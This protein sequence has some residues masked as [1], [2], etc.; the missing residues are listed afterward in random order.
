M[1]LFP[2]FYRDNQTAVKMGNIKVV[3]ASAGSGK[4]FNLVYEY[5]RNVVVEPSL[6]RHILAVTFTNKATEEMKGRILQRVHELASGEE[7]AYMSMLIQ[8]TGKSE[9]EIRLRAQMAQNNILHDY[10]HFAVLT[11]DKFFQR[12]VRS[13]IKELGIDLNFNIELPVDTLLDVSVDR[14][15]ESLATDEQLREWVEESIGDMLD[16]GKAWDLRN[17]WKQTGKDLF[18][19]N[20]KRA[21]KSW[22]GDKTMLRKI[23]DAAR[24]ESNKCRERIIAPAKRILDIIYENGLTIDDIC[25]K[26]KGVAGYVA[27]VAA[28]NISEYG[29]RVTDILNGGQWYAKSASKSQKERI[30]AISPALTSLLEELVTE[31]DKGVRLIHTVSILNQRYRNFALLNDIKDKMDEVAKEENIV[32]ISEINEMLA[33]LIS[34]N[35]TP[36]VFEKAGNYYSHFMIDEFQDTSAMQWENFKPLLR[37]AVSQSEGEP[38]MLVG[39]I[40]QSIYR[41]RGGDWRIL[42]EGVDAAFNN[43]RHSSLR[44]NYRSRRMVVDFVNA[45]MSECVTVENDKVNQVLYQAMQNGNIPN[46]LYDYLR[47]TVATV[48]ADCVQEPA[49]SE[50]SGYVTITYYADSVPPIISMVEQLQERGYKAGDIAILVRTNNEARGIAEMMLEYKMQNHDSQYC[51]DVI[52]QDALVVGSSDEVAFI[53]ACLRL[54]CNREL[55]IAKAVYNRFL[56][57]GV[58]DSFDDE[59]EKFF[60]RLSMMPPEEAFEAVVSHCSLSGNDNAVLYMQALQDQI[61]SFSKTHVADISLFLEQW[62]EQGSSASIPMSA[63]GN[64]ITIDTIHRSK[65]L[66]YKAV[67]IPYCDWDM[68]PKTSTVIWALQHDESPAK[69]LGRFP[70]QYTDLTRNSLFSADYYNEYVMAQIDNLNLL[71]VAMTRAGEELHIMIPYDE[72]I[73]NHTER[74]DYLWHRVLEVNEDTAHI[75]DLYGECDTDGDMRVVKFGMPCI[76][77]KKDEDKQVNI[78]IEYKTYQPKERMT[79]RFDSQRYTEDGAGDERLSPRDYGTLLHKLFEVADDINDVRNGLKELQD[80]GTLSV[81]EA[82][83]LLKSMQRVL[84]D[85]VAG[86]WF[87]GSW[88][89]IRNENAI[90]APGGKSY[91]PDRVMIKDN[92]VV[93]VDYKFGMRHSEHSA[94]VRRYMAL[95]KTMGYSDVSG[96]VWYVGLGKV[97]QVAP[98][99]A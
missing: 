64:A 69:E 94:Q 63:K 76:P 57:R 23:V 11:I 2:Y 29:A 91:R 96:Y 4:T 60:T 49:S 51:Y 97:E 84:E 26:G 9:G 6:Y 7:C 25:N 33:K 38:V 86:S 81:G 30:A 90:I 24:G 74:V 31:Y 87:D 98:E 65:G 99:M 68:I 28:G 34:D 78:K 66:E 16:D 12:I 77:R 20:Y 35:D 67:I 43:V 85:E 8:D 36:F 46:E 27:K 47:D 1:P 22:H 62:D 95:L 72:K 55:S 73:A 14:M 3:S 19:E 45:A 58:G 44:T 41:W 5:V 17:N 88:S 82:D 70:V 42:A 61:L 48:Y 54:A 37:N 59:D 52:T 13:F 75:G 89:V 53:I 56:G 10:G 32:H 21:G 50:T 15:I 80:N 39:D 83:M 71:Y 93:V 92:R 40:K 18:S 79:V